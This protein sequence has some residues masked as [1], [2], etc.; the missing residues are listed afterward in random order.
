M[1]E[2]LAGLPYVAEPGPA[3]LQ[4]EPVVVDCSVMA[5]TLWGE[6]AGQRAAHLL[7]G[8]SLH[9]PHLL[10]YELA[11]VARNKA[12]SG[13]PASEARAGL[14]AFCDQVIVLHECPSTALWELAHRYQLTAYDA[15]YLLLAATL[16][17][18]LLTFDQRLS[19]AAQRH[20]GSIGPA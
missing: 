1:S 8:K 15:A 5:A 9:A 12:R 4:R 20:L 7:I 6:P 3:W 13:A 10:V 18:P 2:P 14:E 11:N 19:Q 16:Q 17:V